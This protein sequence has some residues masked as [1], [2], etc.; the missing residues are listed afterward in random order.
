[1]EGYKARDG[2]QPKVQ[3]GPWY[4]DIDVGNIKQCN[5]KDLN[6]KK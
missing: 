2:M 4:V 3:V 5:D 1:M 6:S